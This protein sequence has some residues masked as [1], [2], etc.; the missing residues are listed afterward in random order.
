M[1][2][3]IKHYKYTILAILLLVLLPFIV[4]FITGLST[5]QQFELELPM[6]AAVIF[7]R[8]GELIG[9]LGKAGRFITLQEI[10][11]ALKD[12]VI[13][14]ED[15]RFYKHS[16]VDIIGITRAFFANIRAKKTVQGGSTITQQTVKNLFLHPKR[17]L[18]R[19][20]QE[21]ALALLL[22][23]R[24]SKDQILE[25]YLNTSY[26]GEGAYGVENAAQIFF[27]KTVSKLT[28]G[29][30]TLLAGL[31][32]APSA[33]SPYAN[34]DKAIKRR[35][36]V[37]DRMIA[38]DLIESK[39]A[40]QAK[41]EAVQLK[42]LTGGTARYFLNWISSL[43]V[44][45]FG[46]YQVFNNGLR[47]HTTL[48]LEMQKIAEEIFYGQD[49]QGAL[50]A[51]EPYTGDVLA[52]VGGRNYIESQFNR[53]VSA[54]RQPG[55]VFKPVI[56]AAAVKEGWQVNSIVEDI[57]RE[58]AEYQPDNYEEAYWGPVT[59]KHAIAFSL[60]N[61]AVWTLNKIGIP[62]VFAFSK[63]MG[64]N[65]VA[66]DGNLA[67]ALGGLTQGLT[68][69][70]MTAAFVPFSNGGAYFTPDPI[71]KVLDLEGNI[72]LERKPDRKQVLTPQQAYLMTDM[73]RAV[74]QYG[75]GENVPV[76]RPSAG[77]SGTTNEQKDLWFVGYTPDIVVGVYIGNDD[78][79]SVEGYGGAVAGP[80]WAEFI[81][82]AL[83]DMP[84]R[85]FPIP[86]KIVKDIMIDIFTGLLANERCEWT[87]LDA[88]IEGTVPTEQA[89]C[90]ILP[91]APTPKL[92]SAPTEE[93]E[94]A[95]EEP[96]PAPEPTP[97]PEK[98]IPEPE[99][100]PEPEEPIP[101]PEEPI[102]EP[103]PTPE[104]EEP[105]PEPEPTPEPEKPAPKPEPMENQ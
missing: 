105:I 35:N 6:E 1:I 71:L 19:K 37:I 55:S 23:T 72:I 97:K 81:N 16:G 103:E 29:E 31:L 73:L 53:A 38:V 17:T 92:P 21:M 12:A 101:E 25:L 98:P 93:P 28:I 36:T 66:E 39:K 59:M 57:P 62:R 14:V 18:A 77:K 9:S 26:F 42:K 65:L 74:M 80:I 13:A 104:P 79:T 24:Y 40:A 83:A 45:K 33:F 20:L 43:L 32:K 34:L 84:P 95:P 48:D 86:S 96:V 47:V 70:Q 69:L 102:P 89:P 64:I 82:R 58:Y 99:P 44:D 11:T 10:P 54:K 41:T 68:P 61:A 75:T 56:Y 91:K 90:A 87:E 76:E 4:V 3:W 60:N 78:N 94:P 22:E 100:T 2:T 50:I 88:F 30:S 85:E 49:N 51:L 27:G 63:Q 7:D 46:E 52:L 5:M 67:L 15:S 8:E